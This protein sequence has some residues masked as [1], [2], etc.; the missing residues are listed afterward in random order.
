MLI[1]ARFI[2]LASIPLLTTAILMQDVTQ[3]GFE[4]LLKDNDLLLAA[5]SSRTYEFVQP[6]HK[7]FEESAASVK[8]PYVIID[9][10]EEQELCARYDVNAYPAVRLFKRKDDEEE[11]E[12]TRYRGKR[13]KSAIKSFV[14]KH[15]VPTITHIQPEYLPSFKKI[16][17]IVV[18]AYLRPDQETLLEEFRS[19]A[20]SLHQNHV[21]GYVNDM[22]TADTEGLAMPSVVC[23]KNTDGDNKVLNGHFAT[24]DVEKFLET[25]TKTIIG[26][27]N[28]RN[29]D[30]YM[31]VSTQTPSCSS[32]EALY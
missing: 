4:T 29:M 24:A 31:A 18:V 25:A 22:P 14:T 30:A 16:D 28:E 3:A 15:E 13:T 32:S 21:F 10:D 12:V 1:M 6:F 23:Y 8:T 26:D 5:F 7:L 27:F 20:L 9:C 19:V 11:V 17:E 2:S